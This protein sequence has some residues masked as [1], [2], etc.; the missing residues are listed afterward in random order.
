MIDNLET[1]PRHAMQI[2]RYHTWPVIRRQSVGEHT[3]Q[4]M[5]IMLA[6]WPHCPRRI[7]VHALFHDIDEMNGDL[8]WPMKANDPVLKARMDL[9]GVRTR[10]AMNKWGVPTHTILN[11]FEHNFFKTCEYIEM[12][13]YG[14]SEQNLGNKYAAVVAQRMIL[15]AS[16]SM[17]K[18]ATP[19]DGDYPNLV[20]AIKQYVDEREK[21]ERHQVVEIEQ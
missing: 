16:A 6:I 15:C 19:P 5:R 4:I 9:A 14:L 3:A 17:E 12:W 11:E 20:P 21:Q 13:E 10:A 18:L 7:L 1:D 2:S 8:P